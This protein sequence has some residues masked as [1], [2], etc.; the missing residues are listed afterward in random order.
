ML[1]IIGDD[2]YIF[3]VNAAEIFKRLKQG[4]VLSVNDTNKKAWIDQFAKNSI[5]VGWGYAQKLIGMR[6]V[7][8]DSGG[9][10]ERHYL[11]T[12]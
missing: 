5:K 12:E 10:G 11:L 1:L 6:I 7:D 3:P 4:S 9:Y 2:L 8:C